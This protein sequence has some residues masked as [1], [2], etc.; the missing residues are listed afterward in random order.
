[1]TLSVLGGD[2]FSAKLLL[3]KGWQVTIL[4]SSSS[5]TDL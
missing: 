5:S 4:P 2:I 3:N 1:M